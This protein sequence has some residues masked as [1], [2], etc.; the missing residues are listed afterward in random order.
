MTNTDA[1]DKLRQQLIRHEGLRTTVYYD[2]T[3]H[4]TIG[5]GRNLD[6]NGLSKDECLYLLSN[7]ISAAIHALVVFAW[8]RDLDE[9]R[10][11]ALT[12][13]M[14]NVG[15]QT[16]AGFHRMIAALAQHDYEGAA[17]ELLIS[18]WATEVGSRAEELA[19][20]LRTG[21]WQC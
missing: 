17:D 12:N 20:Q 9:V 6:A 15:P 14:F 16:F 21:R 18:K 1:R 4:L 11:A 5:V 8:F 2:T 10:Q 13:F 3:G 19:A 7:D